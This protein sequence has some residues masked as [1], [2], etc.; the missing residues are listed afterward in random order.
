MR[1]LAEYVMKGRAQAVFAAV[2]AT[3]TV[4]FAWIGA[5]IIALVTLRKGVGQGG[6]VLAWALLPALVLASL[7]DTG[8]VTTLVGVVFVAVIL[9]NSS[10]WP[11]ALIAAVVSG[12]LTG[13]VLLTLG[14]G[15]IEQVLQLLSGALEQF[16]QQSA[17]SEQSAQLL[18]L[19]PTAAQVAGLLGL[20]NTLT[21]VVCIILARWWQ[22]MLYNPGGFRAEF[23]SLRLPPLLVIVLLAAGLLLSSI[24]GEYRIWAVMFAIPFLIAGI[25]LVHGVIGQKKLNANWLGFFYFSW[26]LLDP[27]K[28]LVLIVAV[29]DSWVDFRGRLAKSQGSE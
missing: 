16:A 17:N 18:A 2:M 7:G 13:L 8:P 9:R 5:A 1:A 10:S 28:A 14:S 3:G 22:S 23:H 11:L 24:G 20:S 19:T 4:L 12:L 6:Y 15:Y 27:V 29:V 21:V 26:L 25:A